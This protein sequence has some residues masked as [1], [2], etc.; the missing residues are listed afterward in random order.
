MHPVFNPETG[1]ITKEKAGNIIISTVDTLQNY[2]MNYG[3]SNM[4][5]FPCTVRS[6]VKKVIQY[7]TWLA[8]KAM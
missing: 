1:Q 2:S 3:Y 7:F 6:T 8:Y 5:Y 4:S